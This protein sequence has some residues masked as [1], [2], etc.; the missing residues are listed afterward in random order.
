MYLLIKQ[1]GWI[2][3]MSRKTINNFGYPYKFLSNY[4]ET[5]VK[6]DGIVYQSSEAAF[7]AQKTLSLDEKLIFAKLSP[8]ESKFKA[9]NLNVR[10][11]WRSIQDSIMYS[12]VYNKFQQRKD[13]KEKLIETGDAILIGG[14]PYN[15][16]YWGVSN[17]DGDGLNK[18]GLILE[19]VREDLGG[20]KRDYEEPNWLKRVT[21]ESEEAN[22]INLQN[23]K[24]NIR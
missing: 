2:L 18:L 12:V 15:D 10:E 22:P 11:D 1:V 23:F 13:I 14:N 5:R 16:K 3:K 21:N 9:K 19:K 6:Y 4:Y 17:Q 7:H 20:W 8:P 24:R